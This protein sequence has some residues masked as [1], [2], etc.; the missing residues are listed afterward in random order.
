MKIGI[1]GLGMVG[2]AIYDGLLLNKNNELFFYDIKFE[3]SKIEDV[4]NTD[5]V[6]I[7]VPTIPD[8]N[9]KCDLSILNNVIEKLHDLNY[10][11][12]ICIKSTITPETTINLINKYNNNK[13]SFC[14][15]FLRERC[16]FEDFIYN[17]PICIIGTINDDVYDIIK[18]CHINIC[19][20]FKRVCP[21]EAELTKYFQNVYNTNRVLFA[22]GFYE[23]CKHNNVEYNS[24]IDSLIIR[25]EMDEKY[26]KCSKNL[27]GP[28]GPCLVKDTLAF[29][30]YVKSINLETKPNIFQTLVDDMKLY[31]K[32]VIDGTRTENEYFGKEIGK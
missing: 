28:S 13:I 15:E 23:I 12:V 20:E 5:I 29:N 24:I 10:S 26:L 22:N 9:N 2:K 4:F 7:S 11:G 31:P 3:N 18:E 30:E 19:K 6:F 27:R 16:A 25:K 14:P 17:N 21:T 32:T 8:V 1:I